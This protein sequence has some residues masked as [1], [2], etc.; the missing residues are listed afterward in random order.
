MN[1]KRKKRSIILA[2][3][4]FTLYYQIDYKRH[5]IYNEDKT[6]IIT[7]WQRTWRKTC[8]IIPRKYYYIFAP[9]DNYIKTVNYRNYIGVLW[10]TEDRFDF[11]ISVYNEFEKINLDNNIKVYSLNDSILLEYGILDTLDIQR[12][13]RIVNIKSDSLKKIYD[14]NYI[15]LNQIYGIKVYRYD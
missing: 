14:F 6:E 13:K 5:F 15:D 9:K 7:I 12:G 10:N 1:W 2:L 11:K 3:L 8:Y 4:F